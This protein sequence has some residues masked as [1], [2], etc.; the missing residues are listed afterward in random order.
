MLNQTNVPVRTSVSPVGAGAGERGRFVGPLSSSS[1]MVCPNQAIS[2][3]H[4]TEIPM[5]N[6]T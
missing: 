5:G 3:L 4:I 6:H 1:T 2:F